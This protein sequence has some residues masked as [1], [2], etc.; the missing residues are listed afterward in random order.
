MEL[1]WNLIGIGLDRIEIRMKFDW[2]WNLFRKEWNGNR[3]EIE[4]NRIRTERSWNGMELEKN[5]MEMKLDWNVAKITTITLLGYQRELIQKFTFR[6]VLTWN[7][8]SIKWKHLLTLIPFLFSVAIEAKNGT[9][10]NI[11]TTIRTLIKPLSNVPRG[12]LLVSYSG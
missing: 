3:T 5:G 12:I 4:N 6:I 1:K 11:S 10:N 7:E 9:D 2:N 8:P